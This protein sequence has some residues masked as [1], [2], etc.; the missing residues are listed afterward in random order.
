[1]LVTFSSSEHPDSKVETMGLQI[2]FFLL[3]R[4]WVRDEVNPL[5]PVHKEKSVYNCGQLHCLSTGPACYFLCITCNRLRF[6]NM[7]R[8]LWPSYIYVRVFVLLPIFDDITIARDRKRLFSVS[9]CIMRMMMT[10]VGSGIFL[11]PV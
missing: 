7:I 3:A 4:N 10:M 8:L 5:T 11:I 6:L 1:M 9:I 2:Q